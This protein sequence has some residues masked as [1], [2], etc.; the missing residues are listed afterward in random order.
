MNRLFIILFLFSFFYNVNGQC[1]MSSNAYKLMLNGLLSHSVDEICVNEIPDGMSY[2]LLDARER[3][4]YSVSHI[5]NAQ[6]VGY[7]NFNISNVKNIRKDLPIVVYCSVGYR[8]EKIAEKLKEAGYEDVKNLYGGIFEWIN[9]EREV[10][11]ENGPT[12]EIHAYNKTWGIW[13]KQG[14]KVF[15]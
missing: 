10:C 4:E 2:I 3:S 9:K 13:L 15:N 12:K 11:N 8:S 5:S 14:E 1:E 7:D 6:W